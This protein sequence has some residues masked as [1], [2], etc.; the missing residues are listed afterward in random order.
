[1][2][3][4]NYPTYNYQDYQQ[5]PSQQYSGYQTAPTSNTIAQTQRQQYQQAAPAAHNQ[6]NNYMNSYPSQSYA[7]P[8]NTY[9]T[10]QDQSWGASYG[11]TRETTRGAAEVLRNLSNPPY[12]S[13]TTAPPTQS[14]FTATNAASA[15]YSNTASA[16]PPQPPATHTSH[17]YAQ[18]QPQHQPQPRPRSVNANP[19]QGGSSGRALPSPAM[20]A[21]YPSQRSQNIY[22]Q[23]TQRS[24]SPAQPQ[25]QRNAAPSTSAK[26]SS[27]ASTSQYSDYRHRQLPSV[28][29]PRAQNSTVP[30]SYSYADAQTVAATT[31]S[32]T[33]ANTAETYSQGAITVDPMAVYNPH[34][35]YE[36]QLEKMR[37]QK[38]AE[39]AARA[40]EERRAEEAR[41][42]EEQKRKEEEER[43]RAEEEQARQAAAPRAGTGASSGEQEA[44]SAALE[45][46]I[47]AMMA[48]MRELN[49][50]DPAL[51]ARIWEEE[52]RAKAPKSPTTQN[53]PAAPAG[54]TQPGQASSHQKQATKARKKAPAKESSDTAAPT[55]SV[56]PHV[57]TP[58][59]VQAS[60][61]K[62]VQTPAAPPKPAGNT[63][64]PP[65]K[66]TQL[67]N[68]ATTYLNAQN[69]SNPILP[70]T[71]LGMLD[72]NPSY[73]E[74]CEILESKSYKLDRAAF[75]KSLLTAVP[76]VNSASR[77]Q[78]QGQTPTSAQPVNATAPKVQAPPA[79]MVNR[80]AATPMTVAPSPQYAPAAHSP[81]DRSSYPP[82]P[83]GGSPAPQPPV[84]VAQMIPIKPELKPPA[85][86]EEAA[87]KRT[88]NDL[89]D[90]TAHSE[91]DDI[92]PV[93]KK[94]NAGTPLT[95]NMDLGRGSTPVTNFPVAA[96]LP[97]QP[98]HPAETTDI[99]RA[100]PF[101]FQDLRTRNLV[102]PL[103]KKKALRRSAYNIK[104]IARD[105]LLA[106]GRHPEERQLNGHLEILKQVFPQITNES[107]LSTLRW[108]II[109]P[110]QP[111]K[112]YYRDKT[113]ALA[114]DA[115]DEDESDDLGE[116][117]ERARAPSQGSGGTLAAAQAS[118]LPPTN[119]FKIKRRGRPPRH[120]YPFADGTNAGT[121]AVHTPV[122]STSSTRGSM[123]GGSMSP[124]VPRPPASAGSVGYSAFRA[125]TQYGPDGQPLPKKKGRPV[126]WR[127]H[128]HGS[129]ATLAKTG[130]QTNDRF[131]PAQPSSLR[132]VRNGEPD[133]ILIDSTSS[134]SAPTKVPRYQ[135]FKCKWQNCKADL[136]NLETLKKHVHKVHCKQTLR[137]TFECLWQGCG[138][139]VTTFDPT[140]G[141]QRGHHQPSSFSEERAWRDHLELRHFGPL[142]WELGDGP[143]SGL[144]GNP[145][146]TMLLF[147]TNCC[148]MPT[149][150]KIILAT[151]EAA[152]SLR[153]YRLNLRAS[154]DQSR[155]R[156][157]SGPGRCRI[158]L[159]HIRCVWA[160]REWIGEVPLW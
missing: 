93:P 63:I 155:Q 55:T 59:T 151:R 140:T 147:I 124:S 6:N 18:A 50:K 106:C 109:D 153:A 41:L 110:G 19:A 126:G 112:G 130:G 127:K 7:N 68:A 158:V 121:T 72:S 53:K 29:P 95:D 137:R 46:E 71:I 113:E 125:A 21:G 116:A 104:T 17:S 30:S 49:G 107:D 74:L 69:P 115:D 105:V 144:S 103:D 58:P 141:T 2:A 24:T 79:I 62:P 119:P 76:D 118:A 70:E 39:D 128:I 146:Y 84:P 122:R 156:S 64:W 36:R 66:K 8:P 56:R 28:E 142:S 10:S 43:R 90:L 86:K 25:Y 91:D 1:M 92:L 60:T 23:Q 129:A 99:H 38:A 16:Q 80:N 4:N 31:Q 51:L 73:I 160:G 32:T 89:I 54:P 85:N 27:A 123:S 22:N 11:G 61:L 14:G 83:G 52:R 145:I 37:Q 96:T 101:Q 3:S 47:R 82:F 81:M 143:S 150:Q 139:E 44:S 152:V 65:E 77:S 108:D 159:P 149:K 87:R 5:N 67:A 97:S 94:Q 98:S 132:N 136:H 13:N 15:R 135:S 157:Y 12:T 48:K 45:A 78:A 75:A 133:T 34:S 57:P 117:R 131:T 33:P 20:T 138:R 100:Q 88:F 120:S 114:D 42:A 26:P 134:P 148:Q 111:P 102:Q 35:E 40:E 154:L 9:G